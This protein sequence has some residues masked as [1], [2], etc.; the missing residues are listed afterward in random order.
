MISWLIRNKVETRKEQPLTWSM[1]TLLLTGLVLIVQRYWP[2]S[3]GWMFLTCRFHSLAY[4]RTTMNRVSSTT[5]RSSYVRGIELWSSHATYRTAHIYA[6][7]RSLRQA[8]AYCLRSRRIVVLEK[9]VPHNENHV[10][11]K[12]VPGRSTQN[13]RPRSHD[14]SLSVRTDNKNF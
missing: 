14:R 3:S 2:W 8:T 6:H 12:L 7:C 13:L 11:Y 1:M 10:L 9:N 4:G 5:R